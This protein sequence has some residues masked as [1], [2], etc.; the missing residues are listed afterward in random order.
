MISNE[1]LQQPVAMVTGAAGGIGSSVSARL[2]SR[3]YI[4]AMVDINSAGLEKLH[5]ELGSV[6]L[7]C[8]QMLQIIYRSK[9]Q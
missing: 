1:K 7:A 4:V 8:W 6:H 5:E 2:A 9:E 3:G